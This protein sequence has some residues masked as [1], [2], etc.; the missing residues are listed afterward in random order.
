MVLCQ[1]LVQVKMK[2]FSTFNLP[3]AQHQC[4]FFHT[5]V[6]IQLVTYSYNGCEA[7]GCE[8]VSYCKKFSDI[9]KSD[10]M[11]AYNC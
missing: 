10:D 3:E 11:P 7:N 8:F 4:V 1:D 2:N 5:L 9:R 6:R